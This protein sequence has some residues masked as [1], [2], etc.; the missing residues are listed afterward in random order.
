MTKDKREQQQDASWKEHLNRWGAFAAAAGAALALSTGADAEIVYSGTQNVTV[1]GS[2]EKTFHIASAVAE[3]QI[4]QHSSLFGRF[5]T[6]NVGSHLTH[7]LRFFGL[8]AA[9]VNRYAQGQAIG[10]ASLGLGGLLFGNSGAP[11]SLGGNNPRGNFGPGTVDAF[12]GFKL[13]NS[14]MPGTDNGDL[15]W[16]QIKVTNDD[17]FPE[18]VVA[19]DWAYNAV[20][21]ASV[22]AGQTTENSAT[23]SPEPGAAALGLLASGAAGLVAWRK[24]RAA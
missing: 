13:G 15:G 8:S 24:R 5:T 18:Q 17:G 4:V 22:Y 23:P 3:I 12:V 14:T 10:G 11:G 20:S 19:V 16:I 2:G 6:A 7:G 9:G 21:G 1:T